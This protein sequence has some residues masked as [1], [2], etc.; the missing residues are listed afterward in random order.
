[1]K[2]EYIPVKNYVKGSLE[3]S[4]EPFKPP[5]TEWGIMY[6]L[7]VKL[8][9]MPIEKPKFEIS[10]S[11]CTV[12]SF[13]KKDGK[14]EYKLYVE[15]LNK[16]EVEALDTIGKDCIDL[17]IKTQ[18][19]LIGITSKNPKAHIHD[20]LKGMFKPFLKNKTIDHENKVYKGS[21]CLSLNE[22]SSIS[23]PH[24]VDD[25][26]SI[27]KIDH[28]ILAEMSF[29]AAV[30]FNLENIYVNSSMAVCQGKVDVCLILS[31]PQ[32]IGPKEIDVEKSTMMEYL[33][34]LAK[35][36]N[37]FSQ[38]KDSYY[39]IINRQ[40]ENDGIPE[41]L[42]NPLNQNTHDNGASNYLTGFLETPLPRN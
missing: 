38:M 14:T 37:D 7:G 25:K 15:I 9:N 30:V 17:V 11:K 6:Y 42:N 27:L 23:I 20:S 26:S 33:Y 2:D 8:A 19:K 16:D 4:G 12:K 36:E 18:P 21:L 40:I 35:N 24:V 31:D 1:M 13:K 34:E 10:E 32:K 29:N 22:K 5:V 28:A 39:S 41:E 3:S